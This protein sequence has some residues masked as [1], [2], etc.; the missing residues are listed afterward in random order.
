M[1]HDFVSIWLFKDWPPFFN[2]KWIRTLSYWRHWLILYVKRRA[3]IRNISE[4]VIYRKK[5]EETIVLKYVNVSNERQF[6]IQ[7]NPQC[8]Q[9]AMSRTVKID[10][11]SQSKSM[12][13]ADQ[14]Q[15]RVFRKTS[16]IFTKTISFAVENDIV[17]QWFF[18]TRKT[19]KADVSFFQD[20]MFFFSSLGEIS[21]VIGCRRRR[22]GNSLMYIE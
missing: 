17:S 12:L 22:R 18:D 19:T 14:N 3:I 13:F 15:I 5:K 1:K 6:L 9:Q 8:F 10:V 20:V 7:N 11:A 21:A 16:C 4:T 2:C